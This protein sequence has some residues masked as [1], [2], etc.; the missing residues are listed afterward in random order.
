M[1][2]PSVAL[3]FSC[4]CQLLACVRFLATPWTA[5]RQASLSITISQ[6]LPKPVSIESGMPSN[7]LVLCRPLLLLPS[8]FPA[9]GSFPVSRLFA[10][11]G[12]STGASASASAL[13]V[14]TRGWFP[15]G[16]TALWGACISHRPSSECSGL[17]IRLDGA[18]G[19]LHSSECFAFLDS[20]HL[21]S[22]SP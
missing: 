3:K 17:I 7:H 15:S 1:A 10:S 22:S 18:V 13:P 21:Y 20:A 16:W 2:I 11:G 12:Q 6:S 8:I 14:S 5:A 9:S 4:W 19:C